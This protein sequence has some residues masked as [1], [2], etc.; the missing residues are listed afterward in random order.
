MTKNITYG[1]PTRSAA[2][3]CACNLTASLH[4]NTQKHTT[5]SDSEFGT[6]LSPHCG[7]RY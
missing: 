5:A 2:N 6:I 3:N 4:R 7:P 1:L